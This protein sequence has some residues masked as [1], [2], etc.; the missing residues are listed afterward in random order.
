MTG[1][2]SFAEKPPPPEEIVERINLYYTAM[3]HEIAERNGVVDK[4]V[5]DSVLAFFGAPFTAD[6]TQ[7]ETAL[8]RR[9]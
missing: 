4:M 8:S 5:G 9:P 3:A 6:V 1:S 7:A 2:P